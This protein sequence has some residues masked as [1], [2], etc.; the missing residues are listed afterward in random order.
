MDGVVPGDLKCSK[1]NNSACDDVGKDAADNV[2]VAQ[3]VSFDW[4]EAKLK[5]V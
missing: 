2:G 1:D 4:P 3:D 5:A